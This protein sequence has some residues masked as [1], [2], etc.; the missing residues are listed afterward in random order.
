MNIHKNM[1]NQE[2]TRLLRAVEAAYRVKGESPFRIRA[3]DN[4]ADSVEHATRELKDLWEEGRLQDIPGVGANI[5][6]H[7]E[8]L[9]E[10]GDVK[11]FRRAFKNLPEAMFEL[12][13]VPGIGP[14]TSYKLTKTLGITK[15][16]SAVKRVKQAALKGKIR[17]IEGFGEESE[18]QIIKGIEEFERRENRMLLPTATQL[19]EE[20]I[21][22]MTKEK[23][24]LRIDPLG[25]LRRR[26]ATIGDVDVAVATRNAG[27][28]ID[29]FKKFPQ[30][31][32]ILAAGENTA[33]LIHRSGRQI[34]IKTQIP[35]RYGALLQH[36]TGSKNHNIHLREVAL[37]K[38]RS[39]SEHGIK[40]GKITQEYSDEEKFYNALGMDWIPPELREDTGEI[41][42]AIHHALPK[43]VSP[44]QI[45]GDLHIHTNYPWQ[46][47]HDMGTHS[48]KEMIEKAN[49]LGYDYVGVSDHNPSTSAHKTQQL[50]SEVKK[51][52]EFLEQIKYSLEKKSEKRIIKVLNSLEVDILAD[53]KLALP[54]EALKMLDYAV[55]SVHSSMR[56]SNARMTQRLLKGLSHPKAKILGH[57]TGRLLSKREGYEADWERVFKFVKAKN[58]FVEINAWSSRLDLPDTL[59]RIAID[60]GVKLVINTDSH[61]VSHMDLMHYGVDAARRGWASPKDIINTLPFEKLKEMLLETT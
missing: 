9:Y 15:S 44:N 30:A 54:D 38:G 41:E 45:R 56:M 14:K 26:T 47:S 37:E 32:R 35:K 2:L 1:N 16:R 6:S 48:M 59:V 43:L 18:N 10:T 29:H 5:A 39:L 60:I 23:A 4:A 24:V 12:L 55:V 33:R 19:A 21:A 52:T 51:R 36:F 22:Y 25:S 46:S 20:F 11:H 17:K 57:P 8:E 50:I 40:V 7:L 3:Y 42:A 61:A 58:K 49:E 34:D 53:G 28:V 13:E 31:K 27:K